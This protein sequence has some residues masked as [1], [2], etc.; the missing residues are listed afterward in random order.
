MLSKLKS[1]LQNVYEAQW[2]KHIK[3]TGREDSHKLRTYCKFKDKFDIESYLRNNRPLKL[4]QNLSKL[5]ISAH[6]LAIE[7]GRYTNPKTPIEMRKC[8]LCDNGAVEDEYHVVIGCSKY[9]NDRSNLYSDLTGLDANFVAL[10]EY[11]KFLYIMKMGNSPE[12]GRPILRYINI[13]FDTRK[14]HLGF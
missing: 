13:I 11:D 6:T 5:R 4:R 7:T 12:A 8:V 9:Q 3:G 2:Y 10:N 1:H 14:K